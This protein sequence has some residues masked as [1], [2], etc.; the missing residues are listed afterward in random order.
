MPARLRH[1]ASWSDACI[2]N[3]SSRGMMIHSGRPL[4][5]GARVE[6]RRGEHVIIA[7]V[8]WRDGARAGLQSEERVP[9][10]QIVTLGKTPAPQLAAAS[11]ERRKRLR[12]KDDSRHRGRTIELAGV[13]VVAISLTAAGLMMVEAA[14]ARPLATVAAALAQ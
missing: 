11:A 4:A 10:E 13:L 7:C 3:I 2:L 9:I 8:V 1:G 12:A 5:E 6:L 14:F